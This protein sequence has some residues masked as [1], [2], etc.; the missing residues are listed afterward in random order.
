MST[1]YS[2]TVYGKEASSERIRFAQEVSGLSRLHKGLVPV[3]HADLLN[4][5]MI[6]AQLKDTPGLIGHVSLKPAEL[7]TSFERWRQLSTHVVLPKYQ[8]QGVGRVLLETA[9]GVARYLED[10][11]YA[12]AMND[13]PEGLRYFERH[14][15]QQEEIFGRVSMVQRCGAT[16]LFE[17]FVA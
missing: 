12:Y 14:G 3:G 17:E 13:T 11:L 8:G 15:Y 2:I 5:I 4:R 9:A 6:V 1:K 7:D 16:A 10:N